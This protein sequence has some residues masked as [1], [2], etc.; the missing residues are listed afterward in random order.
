MLRNNNVLRIG[1]AAAAGAA[2]GACAVFGGR[3]IYLEHEGTEQD[4]RASTYDLLSP[5]TDCRGLLD[6]VQ[7][8]T[9]SK[10]GELYRA[11]GLESGCAPI[12]DPGTLLN[13]GAL[14]TTGDGTPLFNACRFDSDKPNRLNVVVTYGANNWV[15]G[16]V[17]LSAAGEKAA[18]AAGIPTCESQ[19]TP[20]IGGLEMP[21]NNL[22]LPEQPSPQPIQYTA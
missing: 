9:F 7:Q 17:N 3:M 12:Y 8:V 6:G 16:D 2:L 15:Q 10:D 1:L 5:G 11:T 13:L 20:D 18:V 22:P 14:T 19:G 21:M 4:N